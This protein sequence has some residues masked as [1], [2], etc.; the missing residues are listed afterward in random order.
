[1]S[2]GLGFVNCAATYMSRVVAAGGA[3]PGLLV[4]QAIENLAVGFSIAFELDPIAVYPFYGGVAASHSLNLFGTKYQMQWIGSVTH[5]SN[6]ITSDG[7]TGYGITGI[8]PSS[9]M[10][11]DS[12]SMGFYSRTNS[13]IAAY[14]MGSTDGVHSEFIRA[15]SSTNTFE[16]R[17]G[18]PVL[19]VANGDSRGFF[20]VNRTSA[21]Y[22]YET[23]NGLFSDDDSAAGGVLNNAMLQICWLGGGESVSPRNYALAYVSQARHDQVGGAAVYLALYNS[24]QAYQTALSRNV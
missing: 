5:N 12:C 21:S 15:N 1:M 4:Q 17:I 10:R 9:L 6:G 20:T 19:T 14:D 8:I 3:T 16:S 23:R 11:A 13:A 2:N 22:E 18:S 7:S 24:V